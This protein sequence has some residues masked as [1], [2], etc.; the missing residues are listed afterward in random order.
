M[1]NW[2]YYDANG[3]KQ[4]P[5]DGNKL[6]T[7]AEQGV[8]NSDTLIETEGG[9]TA[10]A[11]KINGL[12]FKPAAF[13]PA[14]ESNQKIDLDS[15]G[16][17]DHNIPYASEFE[18][19]ESVDR[20]SG[21]NSMPKCPEC[22]MDISQTATQCPNCGRIFTESKIVAF[23]ASLIIPGL[24]QIVQKRYFLGYSIIISWLLVLGF[25]GTALTQGENPKNLHGTFLFLHSWFL[26]PSLIM[27]LFYSHENV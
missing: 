23:L 6:K 18:T 17:L 5:I 3:V 27:S 25:F 4:G 12:A 16:I 26:V 7:L 10:T 11:D 2:Y 22:G 15:K 21:K 9:K 20:T 8:V 1:T 13:K 14:K 19:K 24:G